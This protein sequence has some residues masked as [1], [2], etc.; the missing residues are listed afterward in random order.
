MA[1]VINGVPVCVAVD[2]GATAAAT[3]VAAA[4]ADVVLPMGTLTVTGFASSFLL[5]PNVPFRYG[6]GVWLWLMTRDGEPFLSKFGN[7]FTTFRS[8]VYDAGGGV[9]VVVDAADAAMPLH[10]TVAF[11]DGAPDSVAVDVAV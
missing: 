7:F 11:G 5:F 4:T 9:V 3:T 1:L 6:P 2:D 8:E 10:V